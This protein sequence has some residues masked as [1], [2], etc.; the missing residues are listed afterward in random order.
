MRTTLLGCSKVLSSVLNNT[1]S[2]SVQIKILS[3]AVF[4][5]YS[6]LNFCLNLCSIKPSGLERWP[7]LF[8]SGRKLEVLFRNQ[9]SFYMEMPSLRYQVKVCAF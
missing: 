9:D 1:S 5:L 8:Q 3:S 4:E 2:I 6:C 7:N